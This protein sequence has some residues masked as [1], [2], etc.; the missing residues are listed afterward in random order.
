MSKISLIDPSE[1]KLNIMG[2]N[3][4]GFTKGTFVTVSRNDP[5]FTQKRSLKGK[6]QVRKNSKSFY[7]FNFVLDSGVSSNAW[8]HVLYQMQET[9]GISFPIPVLFKDAMGTSTFFCKAS[10]F[11]EPQA[12]FG[13]E[14][15]TREWNLVCNEVTHVIG[16]N[17]QDDKIA[18]VISKIRTAIGIAGAFGV[19]V[20]SFVQGALDTVTDLFTEDPN[21]EGA[22]G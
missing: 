2:V 12:T 5:T 15:T 1:F 20:D 17:Q 3:V 19:N 8:I 10:Y 22:V 16:S 6:T 9:Y 11:Q 21:I 13:N 18:D 7:T 14:S 4:T